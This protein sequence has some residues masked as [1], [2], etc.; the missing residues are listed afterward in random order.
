MQ[1]PRLCYNSR[2]KPGPGRA[3]ARGKVVVFVKLIKKDR[4]PRRLAVMLLGILI[5]G[6]GVGLFKVSL[7]GNDPSTALAIA[8]GGQVG[9]DFSICVIILNCL[10]FVVEL[11]FARDMVG[12][13]TVVNW[14]FVGPIA[15]FFEKLFVGAFGEPQ[16]FP[17][18]LALLGVGVLI[19]SFSCALYQTADVGIAPY[20][21]LSLLLARKLPVPYFWCR[22]FTDGVC[23]GLAFLLGGLIGLGTLVCALALGPFVAFFTRYAAQAMV[24][25]RG[26]SRKA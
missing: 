19:L 2:E 13:G 24:F 4:Y 9:I 22:I 1:R 15:S 18:Q 6:V 20:D 17:Q 21:A 11:L 3:W 12:V 25:G 7:M 8:V 14:F 26:A 23:V 10:Y 16:S 5:M